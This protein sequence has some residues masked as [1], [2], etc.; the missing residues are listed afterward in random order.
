MPAAKKR[1]P[2]GTTWYEGFKPYKE[3][4]GEKYMNEQQQAHF[5]AIPTIAPPRSPSSAWNCAPAT[6]SAS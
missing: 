6:A 5:L 2:T 4:R 1:A 3:K